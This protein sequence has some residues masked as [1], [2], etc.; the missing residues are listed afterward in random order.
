MEPLGSV[1]PAEYK[2]QRYQT[3]ADPSVLA[4]DQPRLRKTRGDLVGVTAF[5]Q[6]MLAGPG[7]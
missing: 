1:R 5:Q 2:E 3:Q 6:K 4:L 7:L